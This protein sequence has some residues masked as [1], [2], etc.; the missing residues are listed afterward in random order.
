MNKL[1]NCRDR[2]AYTAAALK[3]TDWYED[4]S[5]LNKKTQTIPT[6]YPLKELFCQK[7]WQGHKILLPGLCDFELNAP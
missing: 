6:F 3:K 2:A 7:L 4:E 1:K 5:Y